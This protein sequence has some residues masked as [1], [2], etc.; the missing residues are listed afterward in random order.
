MLF[1]IFSIVLWET[2]IY[3]HNITHSS[4]VHDNLIT[5]GWVE[6]DEYKYFISNSFVLYANKGKMWEDRWLNK[7]AK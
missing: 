6:S 5:K 3:S 1:N 4:V 7:K 2:M